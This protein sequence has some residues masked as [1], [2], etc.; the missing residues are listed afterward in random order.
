MVSKW[1]PSQNQNIYVFPDVHGNYDGLEL[2]L[3]KIT[4]LRKKTNDLIVFLC[5]YVDRSIKSKE[6]LDLIINLKSFGYSVSIEE[7]IP[8]QIFIQASL[9]IN[10]LDLSPLVV[11]LDTCTA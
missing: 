7:T 8:I 3:N 6:T 2:L 10:H 4:P 1:R 11:K 5:D 9:R